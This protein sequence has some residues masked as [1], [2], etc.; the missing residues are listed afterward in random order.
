MKSRSTHQAFSLASLPYLTVEEIDQQKADVLECLG[1]PRA[2]AATHS[3]MTR[4]KA[5]LASLTKITLT[6]S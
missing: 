5:V 1:Y 2:G 3:I 4:A 6:A